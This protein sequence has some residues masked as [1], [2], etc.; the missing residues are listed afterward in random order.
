MY[1]FVM[2]LLLATLA[3]FKGVSFEVPWLALTLAGGLW[4]Y[5]KK[6]S[7][8]SWYC[9]SVSYAL[10]QFTLFATTFALLTDVAAIGSPLQDG[11]LRH[12]D[13]CIGV[14]ATAIAGWLNDCRWADKI[15]RAAYFSFMPQIILAIL[16]G[17][18]ELFVNRMSFAGFITV[19]L[20]MFIPA[21]GN[22]DQT[23]AASHNEPIRQRMTALSNNEISVVRLAD[24][25]GIICAPSFHTITAVLLIGAFWHIAGMR[26]WALGLNGL[27]ILS[28]VPTGGH[29]V[30]DV[31]LGLLVAAATMTLFR[32]S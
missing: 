14:D 1:I 32:R 6:S 25:E 23:E 10:C 11:L 15:S 16:V 12:L 7:Y 26:W 29:Y 4:L 28:T 17:K 21:I 30:V 9:R 22:Y 13:G 19:V 18:R 3:G 5:A 20:F 24:V 2:M 31:L 27:M 8:G